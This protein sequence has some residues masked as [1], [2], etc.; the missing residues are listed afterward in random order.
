M[1]KVYMLSFFGN[2]S[3]NMLIAVMLIKKKGVFTK[4]TRW[5]K[6]TRK[7]TILSITVPDIIFKCH[8]I[9]VSFFKLCFGQNVPSG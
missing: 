6:K 9:Q 1:L 3:L 2:F 4:L 7:T 5:T 8:K